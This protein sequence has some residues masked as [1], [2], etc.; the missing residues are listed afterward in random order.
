MEKIQYNNLN[1][2][3]IEIFTGKKVHQELE[4]ETAYVAGQ[5]PPIFSISVETNEGLVKMYPS[6]W[7]Q[8][9]DN[10]NLSVIKVSF[11]HY[12]KGWLW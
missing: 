2:P 9:D 4:S 8:K 10:G 7:I 11:M 1:R 3:E 6:D 5:G 12:I